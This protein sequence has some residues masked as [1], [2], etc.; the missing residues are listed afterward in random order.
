MTIIDCTRFKSATELG[1]NNL[2]RDALI[3]ALRLLEGDELVFVS[4]E[5]LQNTHPDDLP[6]N[7]FNMG[8]WMRR[9]EPDACGFH[10][11]CGCIGGWGEMIA[12]CSFFIDDQQGGGPHWRELDNLFYANELDDATVMLSQIT[13]EQAAR[14]LRNYLETGRARWKEAL[15]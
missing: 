8:V 5:T 12:H 15:A 4:R 10:S 14:A 6:P 3:S 1:L 11:S 9:G 13:C 2:H 7:G